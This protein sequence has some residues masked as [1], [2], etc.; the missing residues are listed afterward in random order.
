VTKDEIIKE[1]TYIC[2]DVFD[3][4]TLELTRDM[5]ANDVKEWDS[6][7]NIT[8]IVAAEAKFGV[9]FR[10]AE[11]EELKCVGDFVDLIAAKKGL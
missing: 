5:S 6:A 3:L 9:K 2:R 1:L 8:L 7:N 10:T 11:I 4:P